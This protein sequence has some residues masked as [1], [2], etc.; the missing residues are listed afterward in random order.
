[1]K[2]LS[3]LK[4]REMDLDENSARSLFKEIC[5]CKQLQNLSLCKLNVEEIPETLSSM[6]NLTKL[7]VLTVDRLQING[8]YLSDFLNAF[9]KC[10]NLQTI[11][12]SKDFAES[13]RQ[14][15]LPNLL[16]LLPM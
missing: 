9:S 1:M 10:E 7:S 4:L 13:E 14:N 2:T 16:N 12:V 8:G 15:I 3:H 5:K 6:Q 11:N